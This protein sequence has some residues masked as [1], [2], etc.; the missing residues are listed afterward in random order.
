[1]HLSQHQDCLPLPFAGH[2]LIEAV[3]ELLALL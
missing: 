2:G 1:M 3:K